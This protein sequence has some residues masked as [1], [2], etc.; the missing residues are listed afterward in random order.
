MR[1][2]LTTAARD[3]LA[4]IGDY[5]ARDSPV[6][7]RS[8]VRELLHK[9]RQIGDMPRRFPLVSRYEQ[10]GVRR[11]LYGDYLI[12]YRIEADRNTIIHILHSAQDYG[13]FLFD[14]E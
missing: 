2:I 14:P 7:A 6:R 11:R 3:D 9:A 8:F 10:G 13:R 5:I 4:R 1:V 12:F